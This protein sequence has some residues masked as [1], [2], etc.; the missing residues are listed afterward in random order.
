MTKR[1]GRESLKSHMVMVVSLTRDT[2]TMK[3]SMM[4]WELPT[5]GPRVGSIRLPPMKGL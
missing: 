3:L 4:A 5:S 1:S 2:S